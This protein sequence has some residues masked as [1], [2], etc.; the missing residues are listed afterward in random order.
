MNNGGW[1]LR[2]ML[3]FCAVISLFFLFSTNVIGK[4]LDV[5]VQ[6]KELVKEEITY[7]DLEHK[8]KNSAKKYIN[9]TYTNI[10]NDI[11]IP[12]KLTTLIE[13]YYL[14]PIKD[15]YVEEE[16]SGYVIF[17]KLSNNIKYKP[18]LKCNGYKT[19]G[20]DSIYD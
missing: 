2:I 14:A 6:K 20:Y 17:T 12:I 15:I 8:L 10:V 7:F 16:C 18:Y 11:E 9:N 19:N 3:I 13:N 4:A 5:F 1:G